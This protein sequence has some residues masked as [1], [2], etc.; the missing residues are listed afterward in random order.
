MS[1]PYYIYWDACCLISYLAKTPGRIETLDGIVDLVQR[2]EGKRKLI[3]SAVSKVEVAYVSSAGDRTPDVDSEERIE[4]FWRNEML[5]VVEFHDLVSTM[6]GRLIRTAKAEGKKKLRTMDA[7]HLA[8]AKWAEAQEFH[9]YNV[10]DYASYDGTHGFQVTEPA[11]QQS[12]L[13]FST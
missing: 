7:I 13:P 6:A 8:T 5:L 1:K 10:T 11:C 2:S 12:A 3:T 9:T 4:A